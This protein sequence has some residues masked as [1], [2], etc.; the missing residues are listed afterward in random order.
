MADDDGRFDPEFRRVVREA[1]E[2]IVSNPMTSDVIRLQNLMDRE[3]IRAQSSLTEDGL[4]S[5]LGRLLTEE[6]Y[7]EKISRGKYRVSF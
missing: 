1:C 7:A 4:R 2:D 6:D 3:D 5:R